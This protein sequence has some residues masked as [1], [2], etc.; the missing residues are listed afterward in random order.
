MLM[1]AYMHLRNPLLKILA[2]QSGNDAG[3]SRPRLRSDYS[4]YAPV[5][6]ELFNCSS[7]VLILQYFLCLTGSYWLITL[8]IPD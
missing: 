3:Y 1:Y 7:S 4:S 2:S 5:Y 8:V 6:T